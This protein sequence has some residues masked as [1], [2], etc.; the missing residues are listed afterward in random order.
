MNNF[1]AAYINEIVKI[2]RKKK[3]SAAAVLCLVVIAVGT[4]MV[5]TVSS[6]MGINISGGSEF[7]LLILPVMI[8]VVI[9]LF[10]VFVCIDMFCGEFTAGTVKITLLSP[11][12]RFK[13]YSA[14]LAAAM[15]FIGAMLAF[16]MAV[17]FILSVIM[18]HT[19]WA[20]IKIFV[21]YAVSMFPLAVF[22]LLAA[23]VA[24]LAR[25]SGSAFLLCVILYMAFKAFELLNPS[26]ATLSFTSGMSMYVLINAP[27]VSFAKLIRLILISVGYSAMLFAAGYMVFENKE[28]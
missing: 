3:I 2:S 5:C 14:K 22:C 10:T 26:L 13:I 15:S 9:P 20:V 8:N 6:F 18:G 24:T 19:E 21:S 4:V 12:S 28:I 25:G 7:S 11:A 1:K 23:L 17:S 16:S 27:L